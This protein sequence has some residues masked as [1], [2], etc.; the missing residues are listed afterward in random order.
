MDRPAHLAI[1]PPASELELGDGPAPGFESLGIRPIEARDRGLVVGV[2]GSRKSGLVKRN[3]LYC[4]ERIAA[5]DIKCEYG[6]DAEDP[7]PGAR[8]LEP[9]TID[10]FER[11]IRTTV[12]AD[13]GPLAVAVQAW[14]R[15]EKKRAENFHRYTSCLERSRGLAA[16]IDEVGLLPA[17]CDPD[18]VHIACVSRGWDMPVFFVAQRAM[19]LIKTARSQVTRIWS[20]LQS[21]EEDVA[22]LRKRMGPAADAISSQEIG[23]FV[24]WDQL[25]QFAPTPPKQGS[26]K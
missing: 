6:P 22:A 7:V 2:T 19:M 8:V 10:E 4:R 11:R 17:V 14:D 26:Q 9:V 1:V 25:E 15:D 21:D 23:A 16:V 20:H 3:L 18:L 12:A 24:Y 13:T 5:W